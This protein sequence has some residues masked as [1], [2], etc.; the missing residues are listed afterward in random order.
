LHK[1]LWITLTLEAARDLPLFS[2][3]KISLYFENFLSVFAIHKS[4]GLILLYSLALD[5]ELFFPDFLF[6]Y[7]P[8]FSPILMDFGKEKYGLQ[9]SFYF[10]ARIFLLAYS[11][12]FSFPLDF[13]LL[14]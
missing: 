1:R 3:T 2:V 7:H 14:G 11:V 12:Y 13:G 6:R 9:G 5:R 8:P 4:S 10:I